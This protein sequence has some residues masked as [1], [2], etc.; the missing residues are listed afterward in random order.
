MSNDSEVDDTVDSILNQL[1]TVPT[2]A[3]K[4]EESFSDVTKENLEKFIIQYTS[5]LVE[6]ATESVEYIKDNVQAAPTAEDVISLAELIKSTSSA[7]EVL[8]KFV[9]NKDKIKNSVKIKEM[10]IASKREELEVKATTTFLASRE[11]IMKQLMNN[12]KV[13]DV[14]PND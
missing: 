11:E 1:K 14:T 9:I 8:N 2:A 13:I 4:A 12:A 5:R 3:K 6:N 10:D 7:I